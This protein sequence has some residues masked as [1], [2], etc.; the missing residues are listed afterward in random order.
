M[1]RPWK[2]SLTILFFGTLTLLGGIFFTPKRQEYAKAEILGTRSLVT[3]FVEP[4]DGVKPIL[5]RVQVADEEVLVEVYLIS[6]PEIISGLIQADKRG[7]EVKVILEERPFGGSNLNL[8][9]KKT[10]EDG[11][12]EVRWSRK[13]FRFTHVKAMTFDREET[14][15]LNANL[16]TSAFSKNRE[17]SVCTQDAGEVGQLRNIF[18]ADWNGTEAT[19]I[20]PNLVVSPVDSRGKLSSLVRQAKNRIEIVMEVLDDDEV[21]TLLMEKS[22]V[23]SVR[24]LV[25]P[26]EQILA[27]KDAAIKIGQ[28]EGWVRTLTK[29]YL[30][31]KLIIVDGER[32]YVGSVNLTKNSFDKNREVGI[33]V[34]DPQIVQR[35]LAVFES[36][37]RVAQEYQ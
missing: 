25:P 17:F 34:S 7:V 20:E 9:S 31:G 4:D 21:T 10:L 6:D 13:T 11:G 19:I 8:K 30:H 12:V 18:L 29:P 27:N 3:A 14:C 15:I 22:Q 33:I 23:M 35:F 5:D 1:S 36:D 37:W 32:A 24:I 2:I 28:S 26:P 16:S